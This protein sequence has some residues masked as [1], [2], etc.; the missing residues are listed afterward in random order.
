MIYVIY[1]D[2]KKTFNKI[3]HKPFL[4][5][6]ENAEGLKGNFLKWDWQVGTIINDQK[7]MW[8]KITGGAPQGSVLFLIFFSI[9]INDIVERVVS[10]ISLFSHK[11]KLVRREEEEQNCQRL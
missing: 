3:P 1:L 9:Y 6:L 7:S 2:L 8:T 5:K 11:A 4:L 10:Y